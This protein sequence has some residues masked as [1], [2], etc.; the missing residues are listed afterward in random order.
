MV[1]RLKGL[2]GYCVDVRADTALADRL[3]P[4]HGEI[5]LGEPAGFGDGWDS[6]STLYFDDPESLALAVTPEPTRATAEGLSV[7]ADWSPADVPYLFDNAA[8]RNGWPVHDPVEEH[9]LLP[10]ERPE[11]KLT[12]LL[13]FVRRHPTQSETAFRTA[14]IDR[15]ARL[16]ASMASLRGYTVNLPVLGATAHRREDPDARAAKSPGTGWDAVCELHVDSLDDFRAGRSD[17]ALHPQLCLL[18]RHLFEALWY[19]EVDENVVV[20]PNRDPAPAFYFR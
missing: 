5:T 20:M 2:R 8:L 14:L 1:R 7:D 11:R 13:Q 6:L 17:L 15:Y 9:R 3:G 19:S 10:V 4:L 16:T 12:K 18:E